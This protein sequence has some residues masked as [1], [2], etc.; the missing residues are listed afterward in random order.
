VLARALH[1][2][3]SDGLDQ[4]QVLIG[5]DGSSARVD[6][7]MMMPDSYPFTSRLEVLC[8]RGAVEYHFRAGGR[9]FE[10]GEPTNELSVYRAEGDPEVLTVEQSD[11]FENEVAYFVECIR[12]GKPA[13]RA[14]PA[15]AHRALQVALAARASATSGEPV[16]LPPDDQRSGN[17]GGQAEEQQPPPE[18]EA[19]G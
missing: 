4:T 11:P 16:T 3:R 12:E 15:D 19:A 1:N 2:P 17:Q 8:E 13:T 7:G 10:I 6:G 5:Y 14:T 18:D 9:S